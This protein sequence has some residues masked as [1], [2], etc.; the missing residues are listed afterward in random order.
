MKAERSRRADGQRR[1]DTA[2][3][4]PRLTC[5]HSLRGLA[6]SQAAG[7]PT[8]PGGL[9]LAERSL[10][11][12]LQAREPPPAL[13]AGVGEYPAAD[14]EARLD[15]TPAQNDEAGGASA[16]PASAG[17][18]RRSQCR[19]WPG[20]RLRHRVVEDQPAEG[21]RRLVERSSRSRRPGAG[22][23][24]IDGGYRQWVDPAPAS[25]SPDDPVNRSLER[26]P[27]RPWLCCRWTWDRPRTCRS[28]CSTP[29]R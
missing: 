6:T 21:C 2:Q 11:L 20:S 16:R 5:V 3:L 4:H 1:S 15:R 8:W 26:L 28:G 27:R 14:Q 13:G 10:G 7:D 12:E 18:S 23:R 25:K 22:H 9:R 19:R 29:R 17:A 24:E